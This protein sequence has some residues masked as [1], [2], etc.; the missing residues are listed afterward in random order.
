[1]NKVD[2]LIREALSKGLISVDAKQGIVYWPN[3]QKVSPEI[4]SKGYLRFRI[5]V[6]GT[7]CHFRIHRVVY[8]ASFGF[9]PE[10]CHIDHINGNKQDNRLC[11]LQPLTDSENKRKQS[12]M[13]KENRMRPQPLLFFC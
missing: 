1:M 11:N 12:A 10:G 7:K 2:E 4:N 5:A 6:N 3:G 13:R 9:I 8:I